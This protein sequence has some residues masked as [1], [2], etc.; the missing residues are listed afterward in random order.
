LPSIFS[1]PCSFESVPISCTSLRFVWRTQLRSR[2]MPSVC[3]LVKT[4]P[5]NQIA[6]SNRLLLW[7]LAR[8]S[9]IFRCNAQ[10]LFFSLHPP[11]HLFSPFLVGFCRSLPFF[12]DPLLF[13]LQVVVDIFTRVYWSKH[14]CSIRVFPAANQSCIN[15]TTRSIDAASNNH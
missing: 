5:I 7:P 1:S 10:W 4:S 2:F 15:E 13:F 11:P 14:A 3:Q 6:E 12:V 8:P 9:F